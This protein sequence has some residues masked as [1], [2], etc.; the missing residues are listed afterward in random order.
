MGNK[1]FLY[2]LSTVYFLLFTF[3]APFTTYAG[4]VTLSWD[5][6]TTNADGTP[7]TDL[8]GY[9]IY[10]GTE[11]GNYS[12][13][14]DTGNATTYQIASLTDGLTYYF[15]VTAYD[16]SGNESD[17]SQEVSKTFLPDWTSGGGFDDASIGGGCGLVKDTTDRPRNKNGQITLNLAMLILPLILVKM[18]WL[19][20]LLSFAPHTPMIV[21]H[22]P[23]KKIFRS[24]QKEKFS[25]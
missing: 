24:L 5:P 23:A 20:Y 18:K 8:S 11:T 4:T 10:H 15:A 2:F 19:H 3:Y 7:I 13:S 14:I 22:I 17:Y 21:T 6:P 9:K 16:A 12:Q 1:I 25:T